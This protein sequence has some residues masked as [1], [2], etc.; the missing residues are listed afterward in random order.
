M[1]LY[2]SSH[3]MCIHGTVY[4]VIH[5]ILVMGYNIIY[6]LCVLG[7]YVASTANIIMVAADVDILY[8]CERS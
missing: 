2:D 1:A 5:I 8:N 3:F 4:T 6:G 7:S